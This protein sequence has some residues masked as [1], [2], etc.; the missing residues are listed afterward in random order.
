MR[1]KVHVLILKCSMKLQWNKRENDE[2]DTSTSKHPIMLIVAFL[3]Q[4]KMHYLLRCLW[5]S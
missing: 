1:E 4:D 5:K 2:K 3:N